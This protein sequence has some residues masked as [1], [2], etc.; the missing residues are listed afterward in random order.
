[1]ENDL[2]LLNDLNWSYRAARV[3]HVANSIALF[4]IL[5]ADPLSV[6][7]ISQKLRTSPQMTEK[8]LIACAALGL[9]EKTGTLF[10]NSPLA[11]R[12]LVKT[13]PLYQGNII[14]HSSN[15][16]NFWTDLQDKLRTTA[17]AG[18]KLDITL[19]VQI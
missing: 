9:V 15:L 18:E 1:M 17:V 12:Y 7:D 13:Q 4:D 2:N 16:W 6:E 14:A 10:K 3:L 19:Y 11:E 8:L 5:S